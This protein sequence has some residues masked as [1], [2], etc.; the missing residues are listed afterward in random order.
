[1]RDHAA[2]RDDAARP[3]ATPPAAGVRAG[4]PGPLRIL[5]GSAHP[6]LP[7]IR[8]GAQ[9]STHEL[10]LSLRARGHTVAVLGGLTTRGV[11]GAASRLRLKL[12]RRGY[13]RDRTQGYPVYRAW[14]PHGVAV[15]VARDFSPDVVLLQ[16]GR[17]VELAEAFRPTGVPTVLYFRN[18]EADDLGGSLAGLRQARCIA[19]SRFN[20]RHHAACHGVSCTVIHPLVQA[21]RYRTPTRRR[22]VT[23]INPHPDK[24]VDIALDVA[25]A[26]PEIPFVFVRAWTLTED[27]DRALRTAVAALPNVTLRPSVD[28]MRKVYRDARLVLAPSR[29][30]EAFGRIAAEAHVSGIP[31]V[32]SDRGGLPEAVGP[33]GIVLDPDGPIGPWI[34]AVRALW[35]DDALY[36]RTSEAALRHSRRDEMDAQ[37]QIAALEAILAA[38][39][40]DRAA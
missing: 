36:A 2:I 39:A 17:P 8:G 3:V 28:D 32:A 9:S 15:D 29:W 10:A 20:A 13:A 14:F 27:D 38:A 33:G 25:R 40:A 37:A 4:E 26:C 5:I 22:N 19:N 34:E 12:G 21:E 30:S 23:F 11:I 6:Y 31:V 1:M 16:S 7:Q 24:G 35:R 18:I